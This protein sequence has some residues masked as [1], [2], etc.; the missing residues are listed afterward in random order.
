M[1]GLVRERSSCMPDEKGY[2][3]MPTLHCRGTNNPRCEPILLP[4][5]NL[6][7]YGEDEDLWSEGIHLSGW[8]PDGWSVVFGCSEC[9][10]VSQYLASDVHLTYS[11]RSHPGRFHSGANCFCTE[12]RCGQRSCRVPTKVHVEKQGATE[13]DILDLFRSAFFVGSLLCGHAIV[14]V[15]ESEYRIHKVMDAIL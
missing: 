9:G 12:F 4:Y 11:Q 7:A 14:P 3:V 2:L 6:K 13:R 15:P 1:V 8:P 5:Q 10:F